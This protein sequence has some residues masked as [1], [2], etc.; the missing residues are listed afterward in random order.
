M[1]ADHKI[2]HKKYDEDF[3]NRCIGL[4]LQLESGHMG[5]DMYQHHAGTRGIEPMSGVLTWD[6][7]ARNGTI[8]RI[9]KSAFTSRIQDIAACIDQG[10]P[11]IAYGPVAAIPQLLKS[12]DSSLYVPVDSSPGIIEQDKRGTP[13]AKGCEIKPAVLDFFADDNP[14]LVDQPALGVLLG[15]T[16]DN[17]PGPVPKFEPEYEL[18]RAFRNLIRPMP[19]G[20]YFLVSTDANQD[21]NSVKR[22][23][24]EKWH[25]LFGVNFL[26]RM[27]AELPTKGFNPNYF[28]YFPVW[29]EHCNLL[30][31]AVRATRSQNFAI[32]SGTGVIGVTVKEGDIFH[33]NNSFKY[34][35]EFFEACAAKAGLK[36]VKKWEDDSSIK[37]YL[38]QV[39]PSPSLQN[40]PA[41]HLNPQSNSL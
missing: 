41:R 34:R 5:A 13:L 8:P 25:R 39:P 22:L 11:T 6:V 18:V 17:I 26:Y 30:A 29:Y 33:Y 21:G 28:E 15:L 9:E 32:G 24:N 16:I 27:Q 19:H 7:H 3:I 40:T 14:A 37:L 12:M 35:P 20:G 23:Y 31:H 10:L 36:P 4:W 2:K 1:R 38:F